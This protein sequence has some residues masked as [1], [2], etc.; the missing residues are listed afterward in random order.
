MP[1]ACQSFVYIVFFSLSN[2][3]VPISWKEASV[4]H[5]FKK[6]DPSEVSNYRPILL[7]NTIGKV[8]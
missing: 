6:D 8:F 5:I 2:S 4:T 7:L 1:G 3:D